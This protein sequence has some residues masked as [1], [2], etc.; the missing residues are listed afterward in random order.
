NGKVGMHGASAPGIEALLTASAS[1]PHLAA[2]VTNAAYGDP[3]RDFVFPG[4]ISTTN[5]F[6][7]AWY[8][9]NLI[10][11]DAQNQHFERLPGLYQSLAQANAHPTFDDWWRERTITDYPPTKTPVLAY[12]DSH[13]IWPRTWLELTRWLQP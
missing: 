9:S 6:V 2:V 13:D 3:Y 4:G 12:T 1:P 5:T 8:N 11:P 7:D 10:V